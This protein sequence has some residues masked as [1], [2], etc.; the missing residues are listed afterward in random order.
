VLK[1]AD[2]DVASVTLDLLGFAQHLIRLADASRV[3][4]ENFEPAR[5]LNGTHQAGAPVLDP[6]EFGKMRT[7]IPSDALMRRST[8]F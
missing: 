6:A 2:D 3:A 5:L 7:S 4:E 1:I 8:G